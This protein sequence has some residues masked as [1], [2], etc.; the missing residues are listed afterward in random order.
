[1]SE[2]THAWCPACKQ[3]S[4]ISRQ[5]R[6]L[7]CG[8]ET[9]QRKKRGG[10][11]RP[12]LR[13]SKYS[14][15]QL[16]ALHVAHLRGQSMNSLAKQTYE[17][18]GYASHGSAAT[19]ISRA[20]KQL[21]L[22][23]RDR[24]EMVVAVSTKHGHAP[25]SRTHADERAYRRWLQEQRGWRA[26]QSPGRPQCAGVKSQ[27]PR[28][29][30][31]CERP[32]M[33]GSD[34]CASHDPVRELV[35]RANL[36]RARK[37]LPAGP[38]VPMAPF[39]S[40]LQERRA[41]LGTFTAVAE[42]VDR[43]VSLICSYAKGTSSTGKPLEEIGRET[44]EDWLAADGTTTIDDLYPREQLDGRAPEAVGEEPQASQSGDAG[45]IPASRLE[46][47]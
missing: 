22:R 12:D 23:A 7:W 36:A 10:W 47:A 39:A 45:S 19:S 25:R 42:S 8:G 21:G 33:E 37:L 46:A 31:P 3:E 41:E 1:M 14:E 32:A 4:A 28:K 27:P 26:Q 11:T 35:R 43:H 44:V 34:F 9:I 17:A 38:M 5:R 13:G 24:I 16:R 20:W 6:C 30:E 40:W 29:G 2:Q 15:A 18:V